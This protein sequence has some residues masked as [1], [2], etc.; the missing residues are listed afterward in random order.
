MTS[1][2]LQIRTNDD[3][4]LAVEN[5]FNYDGEDLE[6]SGGWAIDED[7]PLV[8]QVTETVANMIPETVKIESVTVQEI[9]GQF[10]VTA[11][12]S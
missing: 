11:T 12:L 4:L 8:A 5:Y 6:D 7:S 3:V 9:G 10:F 1:I 2:E